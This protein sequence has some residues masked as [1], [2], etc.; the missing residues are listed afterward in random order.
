MLSTRT[1]IGLVV[2]SAIVGIGGYAL[3]TS[4]GLQQVNFDDTFA[5]GEFTTYKFFAPR[6]ATQFV[7]IT[8]D[9]FI[10]KLI[11]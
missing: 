2:G 4:F 1:I 7:N 10:L 11:I 5:P 8:G 9:T 3:V 6:S